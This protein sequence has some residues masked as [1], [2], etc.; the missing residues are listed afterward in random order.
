MTAIAGV[1]IFAMFGAGSTGGLLAFAIV[2][3]IFAGGCEYHVYTSLVDWTRALM[4]VL[5]VLSLVAPMVAMF[6]KSVDE[7]GY[8]TTDFPDWPMNT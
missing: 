1:L 4:N 2:Y 3:G 8:V 7:V 6:A 5:T